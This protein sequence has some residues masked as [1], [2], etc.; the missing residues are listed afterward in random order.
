MYTISSKIKLFSIILVVVGAIGLIAGFIAAP[1]SIED[2]KEIMASHDG[3]A[4]DHAPVALGKVENHAKTDAV[5]HDDVKP[6]GAFEGNTHKAANDN[7][8]DAH[9]E[10][11]H[12]EHILH[13]L[14][15]RPWA[16]LYIAAFFFFMIALGVLVFY[17]IQFAAQAGWSPVLFRIMEAITAYL[18]PGGIIMFVILAL[19]GFH[20][21]HLF[22]WADPE[23]VAHDELIQGKSGWLNGTGLVIRAA[24]F[25]AGWCIYRHFAV[26]YSR[27][28]DEDSAGNVWYKKSFKI[29]AGFLVFF[30]YTESMMSWDWIMS[31]DPHWFSTLF[32]WYV[33]ASLFVSGITVIALITIYLKS[34]GYL[35]FVNNSHIHDLAKFMFGI[36]IFWT[37]LWFSQFMLIWYSNIPE[38]VTYYITRIEDYKL[39]FFGMLVMNFLFP[40]LLLMNS[41]FKR[42]NW[43]VVMAGVVILC[44]HYIDVY[45]MVMPATVGE[46]WFIGLPEVSAVLL[47]LGL[48]LFIVFSALTKAP[49]L[50]KGNPF[51]EESKHF[52][53]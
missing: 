34:K 47:F 48:F 31:F 24:I 25:L 46:S 45:N 8:K 41:D 42:I 28:Q 27:K 16:S 50:A 38:E 12:Y 52:H 40:L 35:D 21:N 44:G 39:P 51:I 5:V 13:Q 30:I 49:L 14:Q 33:F 3:H 11:E 15:N 9:G 1:S 22:V 36:S 29:A 7:Q 23:V 17:A 53:Y 19:S 6:N 20:I 4:D 26:K 43:F 37:Y 10:D 32:G 2:V 18:L